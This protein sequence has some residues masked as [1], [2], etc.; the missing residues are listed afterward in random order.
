M[1]LLDFVK[2]RY[3]YNMQSQVNYRSLSLDL[4]GLKMEHRRQDKGR[5]RKWALHDP[6][7]RD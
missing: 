1:E 7:D 4:D 5:L 6:Q 3:I 2:Y